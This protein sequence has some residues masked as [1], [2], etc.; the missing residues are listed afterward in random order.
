MGDV[1]YHF[2]GPLYFYT[3]FFHVFWARRVT[4]VF[5]RH[6]LPLS[7][8][9]GGTQQSFALYLGFISENRSTCVWR[10]C[11]ELQQS[12]RGDCLLCTQGTLREQTHMRRGHKFSLHIY[13]HTDAVRT[14][15]PT[16]L[17]RHIEMPGSG[18][19]RGPANELHH[20]A[21]RGSAEDTLAVLSDGSIVINHGT[22]SGTTPLTM[23]CWKGHVRVARILVL[24]EANLSI[25]DGAA[26]F[27]RFALFRGTRAPRWRSCC[28]RRPGGAGCTKQHYRP[29]AAA[30]LQRRRAH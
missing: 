17:T 2:P 6:S 11:G 1:N 23:C 5:V 8:R 22:A 12:A 26:G 14:A 13:L 20:A 30:L 25:V 9:P 24:E 18:W 10:S 3:F 21:G 29:H 15:V 28:W 4:F 7:G 27:H 16:S 19:P